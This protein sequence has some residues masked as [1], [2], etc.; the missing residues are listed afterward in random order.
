M[1]IVVFLSVVI[2]VQRISNSEDGAAFTI[3]DRDEGGDRIGSVFLKEY[4]RIK[5]VSVKGSLLNINFKAGGKI[6]IYND[7]TDE[8]IK[9]FQYSDFTYEFD[10][11]VR[12][13]RIET[14]KDDKAGHW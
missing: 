8:L 7:E 13:I 5:E 9:E 10:E 2:I 4:T 6:R 11:P 1:A 14:S 3:K 12:K